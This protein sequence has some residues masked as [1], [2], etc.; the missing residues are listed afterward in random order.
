MDLFDADAASILFRRFFQFLEFLFNLVCL[1]F[2]NPFMDSTV[3]C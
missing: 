3:D 1:L 2:I